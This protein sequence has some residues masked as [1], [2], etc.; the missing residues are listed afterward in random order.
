MF[1]LKEIYDYDELLKKSEENLCPICLNQIKDKII[2]SCKHE[3]C[4]ICLNEWSNKNNRC[5]M[6]RQLFQNLI[7]DNT[8]Y[9]NYTNY[10]NFEEEEELELQIEFTLL[11]KYCN[12][13]IIIKLFKTLCLE[14][15]L[16]MAA[17]IFLLLCSCLIISFINFINSK[18]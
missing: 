11:G 4:F 16:K 18:M 14:F 12:I 10:A 1:K 13:L 5:P 3:F 17:V 2:L 7:N 6:C 9:I 15:L 8:D